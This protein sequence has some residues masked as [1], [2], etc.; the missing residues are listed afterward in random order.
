MS[1]QSQ[2]DHSQFEK[3]QGFNLFQI[4]TSSGAIWVGLGQQS[5]MQ[6]RRYS[7]LP[8]QTT[9]KTITSRYDKS[10]QFPS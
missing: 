2:R 9:L 5:E 3:P 4:H 6:F 1:I 10:T 7:L 8:L